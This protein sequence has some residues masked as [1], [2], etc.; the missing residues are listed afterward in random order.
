MKLVYLGGAEEVG[1][2][3]ILMEISGY[4][5]LM[6]AGIRQ[7]MNKDRLPDFNSIKEIGGIDAIVISHAHMDHIGSLPL[8]SKEYPNAVIYMNKMTLELARVLLYDS[9][10]IM[11][12]QE[13]EIPIFQEE[14]V[15]NMFKRVKVVSFEEEIKLNDKVS[16]TFYMA[17]HIAGASCIYFKS[18]EGSVLYTGDYS[19]FS[20]YTVSGLSIPR[21]RP[22]VVI[23]EATYGDKLHSNREVEEEKL[24]NYVSE[25]IS[26][27]GK[28]LI[29]VFALGRSQEV[30]LMLKRAMNK[31]KLK[32]VK[33][34]VDG[35]VRNINN[36]FLNNPLFLNE[37]LGKQILKGKEVFYN[38]EIIRVDTK[39][40]REKILNS[41]EPSVIV[42][43]SGMLSGGMSEYYATSIVSSSK[44]SIILTGYQDEE[45]N[46][47]L[48][49]DLL[50]EKEDARKLKLN[51]KVYKVKC[52]IE[53]VGLSAHADK[54]EMK[55]LFSSLKPKNIILGHGDREVISSFAS[56]VMKEVFSNVYVPSVGE[57]LSF[58]I[59][60]PR[61]Q[62]NHKLKYL[63]S[64]DGSL[65]DF[66]NFI[67]D[68]YGNRLFTKE[69]LS[70]I[71]FGRKV[72]DNEIESFTKDIIDSIYFRQDR[73]RYFMFGIEDEDE[74]L[75]ISNKSITNQDIE[76]IIKIKFKDFPYKKISYYL[77]EKRIILTFDFPKVLD[78]KFYDVCREVFEEYDINVL[79]N[80]NVNN[81]AC[82][83]VI[84]E[85]IGEDNIDKISFLPLEDRFRVKVYN[86]VSECSDLIKSKIGYDVEF[87][88]VPKKDRSDKVFLT[89]ERLEQNEALI[90]IDNFFK[91]KDDKP[92]K[93]G[94]KNG[95]IV[96]SFITY[97]VGCRYKKDI[98]L[99]EKDICWNIEINR[100]PN[101]NLI[102]QVLNELLEKYKLEKKKN[103]SFLPTLNKVEI[104]VLNGDDFVNL[105]KDFFIKTGLELVVKK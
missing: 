4:R 79:P 63:Y 16:F 57:V 76:D 89:G 11:N 58:V 92:Y 55:S 28:V 40:E 87:V 31:K 20:Q 102:F 27:G 48:L 86:D 104:Q 30:L 98:S 64:K 80:D 72:S 90:Y 83:S 6:D 46:G 26:K 100:N 68:N 52:S 82:I 24:V 41:S 60:N 17:G 39:E 70:Y 43:S 44:N 36:V 62:I 34:Y 77:D 59:R 49:L 12:Y 105:R 2:S 22:D 101:M 13:G 5:I 50:N 9:L 56:E 14:D 10:K 45:S 23:S 37:R 33:V 94:I 29:P 47:R 67:K 25:V 35:M 51:G 91:D 54:Q 32:K 99:L 1:A 88:V 19:L 95:C 75:K 97:E 38:D 65:E 7:K 3:S 96:L 73:K 8:I 85:V 53:K 81:N 71:Y 84:N 21:L 18:K 66:Y 103:P 78:K 15:L 74:I 69:D 61:K 93:K 42:A